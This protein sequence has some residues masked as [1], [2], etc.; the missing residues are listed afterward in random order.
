MPF[1]VIFKVYLVVSSEVLVIT[2]SQ[3]TS[4][5]STPVWVMTRLTLQEPSL[6]KCTDLF[7]KI[8]SKSKAWILI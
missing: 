3:R 7:G 4:K 5:V 1:N 6:D 2:T 8:I